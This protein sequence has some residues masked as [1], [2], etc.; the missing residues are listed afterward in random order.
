MKQCGGRIGPAFN[1][2]VD[3]FNYRA[4]QGIAAMILEEGRDP[5]RDR[6]ELELRERAPLQSKGKPVEDA[7]HLPLFVAANEPTLF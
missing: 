4:A 3:A 6:L 7:G 2:Y 1:R 5:E